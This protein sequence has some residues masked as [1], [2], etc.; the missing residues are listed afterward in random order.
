MSHKSKQ[1]ETPKTLSIGELAESAK[2]SQ[3]KSE[4]SKAEE[5]CRNLAQTVDTLIKQLEQKEQEITFLKSAMRQLESPSDGLIMINPSDEELISDIQLRKLKDSA[6]MRELTLEEVK[7][8][9]LLVKN[10]RLSQNVAPI[11]DTRKQ[12]M[13]ELP[14]EKLIEIA[15]KSKKS[16]EE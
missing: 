2:D 11:I 14:K 13:K 10:K 7:K 15:M 3:I 9:D 4:L 5:Q 16:S 6:T 12:E 1:N 8:F